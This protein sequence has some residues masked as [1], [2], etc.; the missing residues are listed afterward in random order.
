MMKLPAPWNLVFVLT[1]LF[2]ATDFSRA[3]TNG[4]IPGM[5]LIPAGVYR[6]LFKSKS[7]PAKI[8]VKS[9]YLDI[10]PVSN[11]DYLEF[12]RTNPRWRRSHVARIFADE[13]YLKN[14]ADDLDPGR[15]AP[16]DAPVVNVSW[17][18]AKAYA[19]WKHKRLPVIAEWEIAANASAT[20]PDGEKDPQFKAEVLKWY[21]ESGATEFL[22]LGRGEKNFYGVRDLHGLIWEWVADFNSAILSGDS[23]DGGVDAKFFCGGGAQSAQNVDDYPAFMRFAFRGSLKADYCIH[24]LG[25]RCAKDL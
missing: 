16:A 23:R 22:P 15:D 9:F 1:L 19:Q 8:A 2:S 14:W 20:N 13:S 21:S 17:F 25:F 3:V 24:N 11:R 5:V 12:V 6:P 4:E 7:E 10:E 18:A